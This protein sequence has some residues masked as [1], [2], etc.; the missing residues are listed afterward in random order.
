VVQVILDLGTRMH[1]GYN[2]M[3][4]FKLDTHL[5]MI[6]VSFKVYTNA[7][8]LLEWFVSGDR[9]NL[10]TLPFKTALAAISSMYF[11]H[12]TVHSLYPNQ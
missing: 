6:P 1:D 12:G 5:V 11:F 4:I 3:D 7:K 10:R 9:S 2:I 8:H